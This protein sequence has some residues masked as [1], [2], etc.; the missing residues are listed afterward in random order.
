MMSYKAL[1][2]E[3]KETL[4]VAHDALMQQRYNN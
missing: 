2:V 4:L 3:K 1:P